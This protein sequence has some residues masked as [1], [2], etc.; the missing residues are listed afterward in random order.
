MSRKEIKDDYTPTVGEIIPFQ[1]GKDGGAVFV[2]T[3]GSFALCWLAANQDEGSPLA[4]FADNK[5]IEHAPAI[6]LDS[7][8]N[9]FNLNKGVYGLKTVT[10][11][12]TSVFVEV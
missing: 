12:E 10:A 7:S 4:E 5:W 6:T 1:I 9:Y 2:E 11:A 8:I 3:T